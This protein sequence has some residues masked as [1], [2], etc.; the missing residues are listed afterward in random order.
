M[1]RSIGIR[2]VDVLARMEKTQATRTK[3]YVV[4]FRW[5]MISF[6]LIPPLI[7]VYYIIKE[8]S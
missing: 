1:K 3:M 2:V 5:E 6:M 4:F 7:Q 8:E